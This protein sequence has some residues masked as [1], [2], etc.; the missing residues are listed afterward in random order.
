MKSER[1]RG[2]RAKE[3]HID[4]DFTTASIMAPSH[5]RSKKMNRNRC[6]LMADSGSHQGMP[7]TLTNYS[8]YSNS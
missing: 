1:W 8:N 3:D 2:K 6:A 5:R 7:T 4:V